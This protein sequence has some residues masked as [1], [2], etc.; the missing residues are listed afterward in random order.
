M[1]R[2]GRTQTPN[3]D[4]SYSLPSDKMFGYDR[5][6]LIIVAIVVVAAILIFLYWYK[7]R[8][9]KDEPNHHH[10][11]NNGCKTDAECPTGKH[12]KASNGLCVECTGDAQCAESLA[13]PLCHMATNKCVECATNMDCSEGQQCIAGVCSPSLP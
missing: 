2:T 4:G 8:Q 3:Q 13:G 9:T 10:I 1:S 6:T 5:N 11:I 7:R 12:C